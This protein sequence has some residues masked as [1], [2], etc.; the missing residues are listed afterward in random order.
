MSKL[1]QA[2]AI[3]VGLAFGGAS[4]WVA[5]ERLKEYDIENCERVPKYCPYQEIKTVAPSNDLGA[6]IDYYGPRVNDA[7]KDMIQH[8]ESEGEKVLSSPQGPA[9]PRP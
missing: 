2:G 9:A 7:I 8:I 5:N 1:V 4:L 6:F 3:A